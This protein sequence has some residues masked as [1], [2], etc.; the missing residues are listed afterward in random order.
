MDIQSQ[1]LIDLLSIVSSNDQSDRLL[2]SIK[3]NIYYMHL[4]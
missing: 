2:N 4:E 1:T 3:S